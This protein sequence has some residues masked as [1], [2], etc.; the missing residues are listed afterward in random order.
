VNAS[1]GSQHRGTDILNHASI[2]ISIVD[3]NDLLDSLGLTNTVYQ[4]KEAPSRDSQPPYRQQPTPDTSYQQQQLYDLMQEQQPP[5]TSLLQ[6]NG[7]SDVG[8]R[9]PSIVQP[10]AP[11]HVIN[12]PSQAVLHPSYQHQYL[13]QNMPIFPHR[14]IS[15]SGTQPETLINSVQIGTNDSAN[16][17]EMPVMMPAPILQQQVTEKRVGLNKRLQNY[18][19]GLW[20]SRL[21]SR[22]Q[23]IDPTEIKRKYSDDD[24]QFVSKPTEA[25]DGAEDEEDE[26]EEAEVVNTPSS[27]AIRKGRGLTM[28]SLMMLS[29]LVLLGIIIVNGSLDFK[30]QKDD[31]RLHILLRDS[32]LLAN[33]SEFRRRKPIDA[34]PQTTSTKPL[35]QSRIRLTDIRV[36]QTPE[37]VW[38]LSEADFERYT[39]QRGQLVFGNGKYSRMFLVGH[40]LRRGIYLNRD[41]ITL[42]YCPIPKVAST[43]WKF[44]FRKWIGQESYHDLSLG[45]DRERSGLTYLTQ[46]S[47]SELVSWMEEPASKN[48]KF[49]FVRNPYSRVLSCF[50]NKFLLKDSEDD[51]YLSYMLNLFPNISPSQHRTKPTFAE[52]IDAVYDQRTRMARMNE[53][54]APQTY[55]CSNEIVNYDFIGRYE[56]INADAAVVF[57]KLGF[58]RNETFPSQD[59]INFRA[60][61]ASS[62]LLEYY[63]DELKKKTYM[64]YQQDFEAFGYPGT[65]LG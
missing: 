54:W 3:S 42:T 15:A 7:F 57:R 22:T 27:N 23:G 39:Q 58:T 20:I 24:P 62:Q 50:F 49:M 32:P 38:A 4:Q 21:G 29:I 5:P 6:H 8:Q 60:S 52:F 48:F 11:Q 37:E 46:L 26:E 14:P 28:K 36:L 34:A 18:V 45:N 51:E 65:K 63:T 1:P 59:E 47:E 25:Q 16:R 33:G 64:I 31:E 55:L 43:T 9:Q 40:A 56:Y 2:D 61:G 17:D 41:N 19:N 13:Q 12:G 53:H 10:P 30:T 44:V 35:D